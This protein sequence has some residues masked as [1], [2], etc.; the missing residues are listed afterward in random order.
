[1]TKSREKNDSRSLHCC[2]L[3]HLFSLTV[4]YFHL[5]KSLMRY[6]TIMA[7]S[8]FFIVPISH[9]ASF[10]C[11]KARTEI[12]RMVCSDNE[13]SEL[14]G[15]LAEAYQR[16]LTGSASTEQLR[17][18]QRLWLRN[19]RNR[20]R[21]ID[22]LRAAYQQRLEA[23]TNQCDFFQ[24]YSK[25]VN[26]EE[27]KKRAA[28]RF[29]GDVCN[30]KYEKKCGKGTVTVQDLQTLGLS[31]DE[32]EF[33]GL[34]NGEWRV[35]ASLVDVDNDGVEELRIFRTVGTLHCTHS[36]FF[37]KTREGLFKPIQDKRYS[38]FS[39]EGRFCN[40]DL[41]FIRFSGKVYAV[42]TYGKIDT[43]WIGFSD[44]LKEICHFSETFK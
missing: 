34:L 31:P 41:M 20:C 25:N 27:L 43:V 11:S 8:F 12:E 15:N 7:L 24:K 10:D 30:P 33:K 13:I 29:L 37:K 22:C 32:P 9:G 28:E 23:L 3:S 4:N 16:Q 2:R 39:E 6:F 21:S 5:S 40:G 18:E 42:E 14:D 36:Y 17:S 35:S 44:G 1:M 38:V 19:V 26:A